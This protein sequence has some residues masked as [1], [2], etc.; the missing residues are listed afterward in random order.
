MSKYEVYDLKGSLILAVSES[1][2]L[3]EDVS[4]FPPLFIRSW[5]IIVLSH[6]FY[7][8]QKYTGDSF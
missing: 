5:L 6:Q 7:C 4:I 8:Y 2:N 3:V 1:R